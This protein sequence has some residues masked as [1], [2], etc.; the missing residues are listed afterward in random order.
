MSLY[1][2]YLSEKTD[3]EI[4]ETEHGFATYSFPDP[5]TVY[6]EDIYVL[7]KHRKTG[8]ASLLATKI[9]GIAKERGCTKMVGTVQPSTKNSTD[10][11]RVLL[12]YGMTLESSLNNLIVFSRSI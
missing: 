12:A 3:K 8:E 9:M 6:I 7:P 1:S 10:S 5:Q 4:L 2:S 11:L